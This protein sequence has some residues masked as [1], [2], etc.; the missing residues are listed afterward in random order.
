MKLTPTKVGLGI[1]VILLLF[2]TQAIALNGKVNGG[3]TVCKLIPQQINLALSAHTGT[4]VKWQSAEAPYSTWTDIIHTG[5]IY[6]FSSPQNTTAYRV[7]VLNGSVQEYSDTALIK[8]SPVTQAGAVIA[9]QTQVCSGTLVT[10]TLNGNNGSVVNWQYAN[11]PSF[12]NWVNYSSTGNSI[13]LAVTSSTRVRAIVQSA[14]CYSDPS[15]AATVTVTPVGY[16]L[17]SWQFWNQAAGWSCN[18]VPTFTTDVTIP[19]WVKY[20]INPVINSNAE[21][22]NIYIGDYSSLGFYTLGTLN[23]KGNITIGQ[24][25]TFYPNNGTVNFA[26]NAAQTIP[27]ATYG[28]MKISGGGVKTLLGNTTITGTLTLDSGIIFL[29]NNNLIIESTGSII[30]GNSKSFIVANGSGKLIQKNIGNSGRTG[31]ILFALGANVNSYTPITITNTGTT[32]D[33]AV[34]MLDYQNSSYNS[35]SPA[36]NT[37][38]A[39]A[40]GKT[41]MITETTSGGSNLSVIAQWNQGDELTSFNRANAVLNYYNGAATAITGTSL[42]G[43]NPYQISATGLTALYPLGITSTSSPQGPP[44]V[45]GILSGGGTVCPGSTS[46]TLSLSGH[47]GNVVKWQSSVSP[48]TTWTDIN[49]TGS[50]YTSGAL[51]VSTAFRVAVQNGTSPIAYSSSV[52]VNVGGSGGSVFN[53][54]NQLIPAGT[55]CSIT[56]DGGGIKTLTGHVIV[57]GQLILTNGVV[58]LDNFNLTLENSATI[59]GGSD[60]AFVYTNRAGKLIQ[61]NIGIG[62]KT[63]DVLFPVGATANLYSPITIKNTGTADDFSTQVLNH[64]NSSYNGIIPTGTT[65][66]NRHVNKTWLLEEGV[67]GGSNLAV[68][69]QWLLRDELVGF[70]RNKTTLETYA[71]AGT[72]VAQGAASGSGPY[73]FSY[74]GLTKIVPI[75]LSNEPVTASP[76]STD[77]EVNNVNGLTLNSN[78]SISS[79]LILTNGLLYL[80]NYDLTI[81]AG[82]QI[83]GGSANSYVVT[84]GAGRLIQKNIGVG[85]RSG[86][87]LFPVGGMNGYA[88]ITITNSGTA[89]LFAVKVLDFQNTSYNGVNPTGTTYTS[90]ALAKTWL[91]E[92]GSSG[93]SNLTVTTQ[94]NATDELPQFTRA[95]L[96]LMLY[97]GAGSVIGSG[98][99]TG[100]NPYSFTANG[101]TQVLPISYRT[102]TQITQPSQSSLVV[103]SPSGVTLQ[104][105]TTITGTLTLTNGLLYLGNY[106]LIMANG[107]SIVGGNSSSY[108]VTNGSGKLIQ[109]N[110][111]AG[112]NTGNVTYP[113]GANANS[114]TPVVIKNTGTKDDFSIRLLTHLNSSYNG[115]SPTGT[116]YSANA[117]AKTWIIEEAAAGGSNLTITFLWNGLDELSGFVRSNLM[118]QRYNGAGSPISSGAAT[119]TNPYTYTVTNVTQLWPFGLHNFSASPLRVAGNDGVMN[120]SNAN[121]TGL[122]QN[123]ENVSSGIANLAHEVNGMSVYPNPFNQ[124]IMVNQVTKSVQVKLVDLTGREQL[125]E[126]KLIGNGIEVSLVEPIAKG[127]YLLVLQGDGMNKVIKVIHE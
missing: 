43:S 74:N 25:A 100:A 102:N 44:S 84:N 19:G 105:N 77:V 86:A 95:N 63:T 107:S 58:Q 110:I 38:S 85:A 104:A 59:V 30:G 48:F 17:Q 115:N 10:F 6:S 91:L 36:G 89:D 106:D 70:D 114:Y 81:E 24:G 73:T 13:Q 29:G 31:A 8:V 96:A 111:G 93:G 80:G 64:L 118:V 120:N 40:V 1:A 7:V 5:T 82:A 92:E 76:T 126:T 123:K 46:G 87:I 67:N 62:G 108:I 79:K 113:I 99:A 3:T 12:T 20:A 57:T 72:A 32:D 60:I 35:G 61:R 56:I 109:Q 101:I 23:V 33:Y 103:N 27:A 119:G 45:G 112:G 78:T 41:W 26:G 125:I 66:A 52:T 98:A 127:I 49:H 97:N 11:D 22:N 54:G 75:G 37:Y 50:T 21:A 117:V 124:V 51:S 18:Q 4:V 65:F 68:T 121:A 16:F 47:T 2:S 14:P 55:Y 71:G 116:T 122:N 39:N 28:A 90:A 69:V 42:S 53:S 83:V 15:T 34:N 88:P 94:W 9:N